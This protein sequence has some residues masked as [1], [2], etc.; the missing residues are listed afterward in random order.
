MTKISQYTVLARKQGYSYRIYYAYLHTVNE[1]YEQ[2]RAHGYKVK[3]VKKGHYPLEYF[4]DLLQSEPKKSTNVMC[5]LVEDNQFG[6]LTIVRRKFNTVGA[7]ARTL[8]QQGYVIINI[9]ETDTDN[10][11]IMQWCEDHNKD[12]PSWLKEVDNG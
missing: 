2:F 1:C 8:L 5:A 7:F 4:N 3:K 10:T 9:W 11:E 6:T 12:L